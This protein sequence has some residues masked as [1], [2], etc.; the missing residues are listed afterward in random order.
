MAERLEDKMVRARLHFLSKA[1]YLFNALLALI[2]YP[3]ES[4]PTCAVTKRMVLFYNPKYFMSLTPE[5]IAARLWH[6][7][8]HIQRC[9]HER[10]PGVDGETVNI[11]ADL[12]INSNGVAEGWDISDGLL[13]SNYGLPDGLTTEEYYAKLPKAKGV[14]RKSQTKGNDSSPGGQRALGKGGQTTFDGACGS[15]AGN[16]IEGEEKA[17]EAVNARSLAEVEVVKIAVAHDILKA[18]ASSPGSV[19]GHWVEWAKKQGQKATVRWDIALRKIISHSCSIGRNQGGADT[20]YEDTNWKDLVEEPGVMRPV[21]RDRQIVPLVVLDTSGSMRKERLS[22][23]LIETESC[24]KALGI[25]TCLFMQVD[26]VVQKIETIHTRDL[27]RMK[28][29]GRGG[30]S[31]YPAFQQMERM[32]KKPDVLIYF[33]D[34][35]GAAPEHP[36]RGVTTIW[37]LIGT[38]VE[39][40]P[41]GHSIK[42]PP[43]QAEDK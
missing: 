4:V 8:G 2:P 9:T 27:S 37:V 16:P 36:P 38:N 11:C 19:P 22:K 41:W 3:T 7:V 13:P 32:R 39:K 35:E 21:E 23:G 25:S 26:Y 15:A 12:A 30:T 10:L 33:T 31:F 29:L 6:E 24:L 17:E 20:T 18:A 1:P 40:M 43:L 28:I 34:G 5:Q 42:V 14:P